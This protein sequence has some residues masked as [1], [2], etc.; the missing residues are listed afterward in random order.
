MTFDR[1]AQDPKSDLVEALCERTE[2]RI[3]YTF[4]AWTSLNQTSRGIYL[5]ANA[6]RSVIGQVTDLC[7][8]DDKLHIELSPLGISPDFVLHEPSQGDWVKGQK[9]DDMKR[10]RKLAGIA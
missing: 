8:I 2:V 4:N 5:R 1:C 10:R 6:E 9:N 7:M 3:K